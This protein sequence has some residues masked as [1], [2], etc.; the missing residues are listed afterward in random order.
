V[1]FKEGENGE[2]QS[3]ERNSMPAIVVNLSS[4]YGSVLTVSDFLPKVD[5]FFFRLTC[6]IDGCVLGNTNAL[7]QAAL[8]L[9]KKKS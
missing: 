2:R 4:N 7:K 3:R 5:D 9:L 1:N 8:I 6:N